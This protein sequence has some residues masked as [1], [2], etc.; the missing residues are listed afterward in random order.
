MLIDNNKYCPTCYIENNVKYYL[1]I[2]SENKLYTTLIPSYNQ[3]LKGDNTLVL[4]EDIII[5]DNKLYNSKTKEIFDV[6]SALEV[7]CDIII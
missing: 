7:D 3:Q 5:Q 1:Y 4:Y 2:S 6:D